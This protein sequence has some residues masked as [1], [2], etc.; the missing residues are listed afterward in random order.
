MCLQATVYNRGHINGAWNFPLG[1]EG[2]AVVKV[3]DGN[4]SMWV[5]KQT[6]NINYVS[7]DDYNADAGW[8]TGGLQSYNTADRSG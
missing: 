2:G 5:S 8:Y 7:F 1:T 3:E 6:M 4:F